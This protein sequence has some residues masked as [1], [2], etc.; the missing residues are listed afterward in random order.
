MVEI[1]RAAEE[2]SA[3]EET[4]LNQ[5]LRDCDEGNFKSPTVK[6]ISVSRSIFFF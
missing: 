4:N 2:K 1:E 3:N 6:T 5:S